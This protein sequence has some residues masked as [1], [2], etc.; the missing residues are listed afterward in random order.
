M[1]PHDMARTDVGSKLRHDEA[2][3]ERHAHHKHH[4]ILE[5]RAEAEWLTDLPR[6]SKSSRNATAE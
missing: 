1:P 4:R 2:D 5:V 6:T 3:E